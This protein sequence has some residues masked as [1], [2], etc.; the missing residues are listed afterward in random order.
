VGETAKKLLDK[1]VVDPIRSSARMKKTLDDDVAVTADQGTKYTSLPL[2][3][4]EELE[5]HL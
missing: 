5:L 2:L 1:W 4:D 3:D